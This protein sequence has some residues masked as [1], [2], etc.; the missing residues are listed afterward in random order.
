[1]ARCVHGAREEL[2]TVE[3]GYNIIKGAEYSVV[4]TE[5]YNVM[6]NSDD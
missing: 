2:N 3:L 6:V 4:L 1:M 5:E